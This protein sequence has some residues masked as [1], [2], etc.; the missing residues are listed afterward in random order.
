MQASARQIRSPVHTAELA[1]GYG[2]E[3]TGADDLN[4]TFELLLSGR[5]DAMLNAEVTYYDY[6]NAHP[7]TDIKIAALTEEANEVAIPMRKG[8]ETAALRE[9]INATLAELSEAGMLT[10]LSEK[11]FGIDISQKR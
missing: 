1:E 3:V 2:A 5:I 11:Y 7:D 10:E 4:Q 6:L 9:E 8:E